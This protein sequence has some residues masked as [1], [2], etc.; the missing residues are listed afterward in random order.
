MSADEAFIVD[1]ESHVPPV[2]SNATRLFESTWYTRVDYFNWNERVGGDIFM[3]NNGV[4][5]TLGY[6][7]RYRRQRFARNY[8]VAGSTTLPLWAA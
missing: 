4:V 1:D 8:S 5:P 3:R 7:Q 2:N 6:Q